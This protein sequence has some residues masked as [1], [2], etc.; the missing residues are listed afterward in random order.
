M[1][2]RELNYID[3]FI[4]LGSYII[5][6]GTSGILVNY[7]IS[8]ISSEPVTN[9]I[10]KEIRD[11]GFVIGKCENLLILT[12]MI[13]EAYTALA[14]VFAAKAIVRREDMSKNTLFFLAGTMI[15]VTY[16]IMIGL[17]LK[18]LIGN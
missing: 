10:S 16:S 4:L 15:N 9:K 8:K 7:I 13:L 18:I 2:F 12:F 6:L 14:L 17:I 3:G 11:T 5:L 1:I